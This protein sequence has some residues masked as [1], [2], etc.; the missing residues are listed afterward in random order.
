MPVQGY[1]H[2]REP[3]LLSQS[4]LQSERNKPAEV[5]RPPRVEIKGA[6]WNQKTKLRFGAE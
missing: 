2:I 5:G 1:R 6:K 4:E 3:P